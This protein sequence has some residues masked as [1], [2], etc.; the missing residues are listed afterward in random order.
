MSAQEHILQLNIANSS[1]SHFVAVKGSSAWLH[2][3]YTYI[4]DGAQRKYLKGTC[5]KEQVIGFSNDS[6]IAVKRLAVKLG[7]HGA[8]ALEPPVPTP[9]NGR[10]EVISSN[11]TLVIHNLQYNDS[12][13]HFSSTVKVEVNMGAGPT[14]NVFKSRYT[15]ITVQGMNFRIL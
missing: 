6:Q 2:W 13:Y 1:P 4:G 9:F 14:L 8:L 3:N 12:A 11:S 5:F 10:V 7:Q 15:N